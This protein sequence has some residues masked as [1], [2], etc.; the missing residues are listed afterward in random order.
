MAAVILTGIP[1]SGKTTVL[2]KALELLK[3]RGVSYDHVVYGTVMFELAKERGL[4]SDRDALRSL[5]PETQREI[6]L[7]AAERIGRM[8]ISGNIIV[9]THCTVKTPKGF[10][11]GLPKAVLERIKPSQIVLVET[12]PKEIIARR[13]GDTS[14]KRDAESVADLSLHQSLNRSFAAAYALQAGA[15]VTVVENRQGKLSEAAKKL[16]EVLDWKS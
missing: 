7:A 6:Q 3:E 2:G 11:S 15:S 10:I 1:G 16:A 5:P 13:T 4:V 8:G 12:D 14:R 9:D